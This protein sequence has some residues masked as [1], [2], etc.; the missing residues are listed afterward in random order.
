MNSCI[1]KGNI[2]QEIDLKYL[3]NG[4]A[5]A[6]TSIAVNEKWTT[7][8]GEKKEKVAFIPIKIWQRR[9]EVIAEH[10]TK[11]SAIL[12]RGKIEQENWQDKETGANR[13]KLVLVVEE[14]DFCGDR[15]EGQPAQGSQRPAQQPRPA[16]TG[17]RAPMPA[18]RR[19]EPPPQT[20]DSDGFTD[21]DPDSIPF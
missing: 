4:T 7:D 3:P 8:S 17:Q 15:R 20:A 11:G 6:T 16:P 9:A 21:D 1:I 13:S 18:D 14:F 12:V 2:S 19:R 5:V 10:F